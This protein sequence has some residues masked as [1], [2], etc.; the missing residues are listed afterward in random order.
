MVY[1]SGP[2]NFFNAVIIFT[3]KINNCFIKRMKQEFPDGLVVKDSMLSLLWLG[4]DPWSEEFLHAVGVDK[5]KNEIKPST[6][7]L[8]M[9]IF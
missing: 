1:S 6:K 2:L 7:R 9:P 5:K 8:N 3:F 4:F